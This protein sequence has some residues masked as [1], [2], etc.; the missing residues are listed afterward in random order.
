M[1]SLFTALVSTCRSNTRAASERSRRCF[2]EYVTPNRGCLFVF[3]NFELH[4]HGIEALLEAAK[5]H[6]SAA[7]FHRK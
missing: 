6:N 4:Y 7:W 2:D 1:E 5:R 3:C